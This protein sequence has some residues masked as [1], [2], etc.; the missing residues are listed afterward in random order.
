MILT[1]VLAPEAEFPPQLILDV[2]CCVGWVLEV[3]PHRSTMR[4]R[5]VE[6]G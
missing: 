3:R 1:A 4:T 5:R 6:R 2:M